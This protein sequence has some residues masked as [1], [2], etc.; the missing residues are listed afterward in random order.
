MEPNAFPRPP[1]FTWEHVELRDPLPIYPPPEPLQ[2]PSLPSPPRKP[3]FDAPYT[4]TTHLLPASYL[5]TTR[6]VPE[7]E[8]VPANLPKEDRRRLLSDTRRQLDELRT[9]KVTDG[10]PR[11]LWNCVN[12]YVKN[13]LLEGRRSEKTGVTLFFAHANGFP[14]EIFEPTLG[15]L[16]SS[17]A[18]SIVD[19]VWVWESVQHGDAGIINA[20]HASALFDWL[21]NARDI[22]NFLLHFLP[23]HTTEG[24][25]P[26]HLSRLSPAE[27]ERRFKSGFSDRKLVALGHSYGG[28]TSSLAAAFYP[29]LF[30]SLILI[31]PVIISPNDRK[32][33]EGRGPDLA[34]GALSRRDTWPS[35]AAALES[36]TKSPFF[37]AWDPAVLKIYHECGL[38]D[39]TDEQGNP[40]V[41]LK[42]SGMQEAVV[43]A[44]VH[45]PYE[46]YVRLSK[47]DKRIAVRWVMPGKP[48]APELGMPGGTPFKVW[49]RPDNST[50]TQIYG[51]GHLIPQEAP[52][53]FAEDLSKYLMYQFASTVLPLPPRPRL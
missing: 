44:E 1:P 43:F 53:E 9:S 46:A 34:S 21:D 29:S 10:Y 45:T 16:L 13:D 42:T 25:L 27:T 37:Q 40:I 18:A 38:Y 5:R 51:G 39:T 36:F 6:P 17:P 15:H 22:S 23:K 20:R 47:L 32:G 28:C 31:D 50:N 49:V 14:K 3:A 8:P 26:T 11:V 30:T 4:L 35:R 19:E 33:R 2:L 24:R 41:K 7:L 48:G 52:R 12:R